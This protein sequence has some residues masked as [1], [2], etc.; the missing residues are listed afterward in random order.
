MMWVCG[1]AFEGLYDQVYDRVTRPGSG[2]KLR[3]EAIRSATGEVRIETRFSLG[4]H[5]KIRDLFAYGMVP[6]FMARFDKLVLLND[7][8]VTVLKEI[9]L[10]SYDSPFVRS[11]R[12]FESMGIELAIEDLAAS[13]VAEEAV[14]ENRTGAR[15]LR[16]IFTEIINPYEFD[17]WSK[18]ELE[19]QDQGGYRLTVTAEMIQRAY[20][21]S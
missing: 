5:L 20:Q 14:K 21:R 16:E 19:P 2:A 3:S 15:A 10:Q 12:Y 18:P 1:G 11:R 17:P 9:L 6:Q 7:L 13:L 8:S 4:D